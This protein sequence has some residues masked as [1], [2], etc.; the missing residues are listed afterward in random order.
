MLFGKMIFFHH[1]GIAQE[2]P[3]AGP[4]G[5]RSERGAATHS[6]RFDRLEQKSVDTHVSVS[7]ENWMEIFQ[8]SIKQWG[9]VYKREEY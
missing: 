6:G 2:L 1:F 7:D 8:V 3:G 5:L 4:N 9:S